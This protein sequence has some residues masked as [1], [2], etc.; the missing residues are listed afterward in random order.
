MN[1]FSAKNSSRLILAADERDYGRIKPVFEKAGGSFA[2]VKVHPEMPLYWG[3]SHA[4]AVAEIKAATGGLPVILDA[5]LADI[6][7]SNAFKA[8]YYFDA[9]FDAMICH[10]FSGQE[11]VEAIVA[12]AKKREGRGVFLLA[13][14][15][16]PGNLFGLRETIELCRIAK[17]AGVD[18][19]V[20]PG[21]DIERLELIREI[22]G[23]G[24]LI[25]SPGIGKQGGDAAKAVW[26]GCDYFIVGRNILESEAP[27]K[28]AKELSEA[29]G[30]PERKK[31]QVP[32]HSAFLHT[33]I[34]KNVLKF[35][36]FTL[37]SGRKSA[38]FFNAGNLDDGE[39]LAQT[40]DA[41]A[42]GIWRAGLL[43][44]FDIIFGPAYKGIP[45]AAVTARSL[46]ELFGANKS[47]LYDRK[48]AKTYSDP[49]D[50]LFVG[51]IKEGDR[52]LMIDDVITTGKAKYDALEKL[53]ASGIR[54]SLAGLVVL[55]NR[56][57]T[58]LDGNSPLGELEKAGLKTYCVLTAREVFETLKAMKDENGKPV[59]DGKIYGAFLE[60]QKM[61]GV[62]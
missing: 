55:F 29:I 18:G 40:G 49:A 51:T 39:A 53:K 45:L 25:I 32:S 14:M 47:I 12:E 36:D 2:A 44:E 11:A 13:S 3:L 7:S 33:L 10:G 58:D 52:I 48:E 16:C 9:G 43:D 26:A 60:H 54:H 46:S 56:Q 6:D 34:R 23:E 28:T 24:M 30:N 62:K 15:T 20:A 27:D 19:V 5:K 31:V 4:Q 22:A 61:Y 41:F 1:S 38:Y 21:N 50:T 42:L 59:L 35:G 37:K 8:A 57:E 17:N